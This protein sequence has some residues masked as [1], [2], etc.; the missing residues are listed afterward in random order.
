MINFKLRTK[1]ISRKSYQTKITN[2][3]HKGLKWFLSKVI[4]LKKSTSNLKDKN[5]F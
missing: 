4:G 3:K 2:F 1:M 5:D